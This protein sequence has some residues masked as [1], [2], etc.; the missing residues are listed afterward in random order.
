LERDWIA[1]KDLKDDFVGNDKWLKLERLE[2]EGELVD[3]SNNFSLKIFFFSSNNIYLKI[4]DAGS[5]HGY[6]WD[7]Y[8]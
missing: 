5:M 3:Q 1:L 7:G 4:K 8:G 6:L 2:Q